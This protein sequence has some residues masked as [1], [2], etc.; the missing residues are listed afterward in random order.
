MIRKFF[1]A[2]MLLMSASSVFAQTMTDEQIISFV[3]SEH[4][5]GSSQSQIAKKLLRRGVTSEQMQRVRRKYEAQQDQL[6]AVVSG[7]TTAAQAS[8]R[9][10]TSSQRRAQQQQLSDQIS[11][12]EIDSASFDANVA[13]NPSQV[14]GRDIFNIENLTFAPNLNMPTP[15]NYRLGPGDQVIIDVWGA[16]QE[17]FSETISPDG[18]VVIPGVGPIKL[19][20]LSVGEATSR[21]RA[22]LGKYYSDSQVSLSVGATRSI[23]V[24]VMGEVRAP[25]TYTLSSLSSA[26]NALYAAGGIS[27]IGTLRDIKVYRNGRKIASIDVYDYILNGNTHGDIRLQDNDIVMVD[28]YDCLVN[29]RGRVK[30]PMIYEMKKDE[31]VAT[32]LDYAGGYASDA[33]KKNLRLVR[34]TGSEYSIHTI[35]EFEMKN[36]KLNDG[37]SLFIDR[38]LV[39]YS[40]MVEIRGAVYHPGKFQLG[41]SI[42]TVR[43]LVNVAEGLREEAFVDR[44]VMHRTKD[45]KTLEVIPVD[46]KG[47]MNGTVADIPLKNN[48]VLFIPN[49]NDM[50]G[51]RTLQITGEVNNPGTFVFADN[52]TIEDL[53]LQAGGLTNAA[54]TTKVNVYRR[55]IDPTATTA[56]DTIT[57]TYSF[58]LKDGFVV[59]GKQ[60]FLLKPFDIVVVRRSPSY[61]NQQNVLITGSVNFPGTYA[62]TSQK[63][64]LSDLV[65]DAGGLDAFGYAKG[66]RLERTFTAEEKMQREASF[67]AQQIALYEESLKMEGKNFDFDRADSLL[68]MKLDLDNTFSVAIDLEEAMKNPDGT[69]DIT[70]REGDHLIVPQYSSTVKVSGDVSYPTSMNYKKGKKLKYYIKRAGGYGNAARKKRVYAI[71]MNGAVEKLSH[72]SR[73]AIQPGCEIVVPSKS[74]TNRMSTAEAVSLGTSATSIATMLITIANI[75]K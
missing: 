5:H 57:E 73:S 58:A 31:S 34:K 61:V 36:F 7:H 1:V 19:S 43:E 22:T 28:A 48:D 71:Y 26:F 14:F 54:S 16:A 40:N 70:L 29:I 27:D 20:G 52:T 51:E 66:A 4:E 41:G 21:L 3:K 8:S 33:Y 9:L 63:Y 42:S 68:S 60:G 75:L 69:E 6:G 24:Q 59:D 2:A 47:V 11:M 10:R 15:T 62:M 45:D 12:L 38:I 39:R 46:I 30:R 13:K 50:I 23:Q 74:A 72:H 44:A 55:I 65:K 37:D 25:G 18:V 56:N 35:D 53:V 67:R 32:I 17:S 49:K 64:S